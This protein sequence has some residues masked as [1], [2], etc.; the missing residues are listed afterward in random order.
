MQPS[1]VWVQRTKEGFPGRR[2]RSM[3]ATTPLTI[4]WALMQVQISSFFHKISP[5]CP[6]EAKNNIFIVLF[7]ST[8]PEEG[9]WVPINFKWHVNWRYYLKHSVSH[10]CQ[11]SLPFAALQGWPHVLPVSQTETVK[12][13]GKPVGTLFVAIMFQKHLIFLLHVHR[14]SFVLTVHFPHPPCRNRVFLCLKARAH[15]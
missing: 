8:N 11:Q 15:K 3:P 14:G 2:F 10:F 9:I 13:T 6:V 5:P 1:P 12:N 4:Q 7:M